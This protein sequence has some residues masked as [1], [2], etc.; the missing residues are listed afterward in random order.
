MK[1]KHSI[2]TLFSLTIIFSF[3]FLAKAQTTTTN[4]DKVWVQM[5]KVITSMKPTQFKNKVY[6][7]LDFW[8]QS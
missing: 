4:T 1:I 3:S 7:I 5:N 2:V 6:N 8:C